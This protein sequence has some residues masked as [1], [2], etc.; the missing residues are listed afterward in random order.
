MASQTFQRL[1]QRSLEEHQQIHFY[2]DQLTRAMQTLGDVSD[3]EPIRRLA[4]QIESLR[5][6]IDEHFHLEEQSG[7]FQAVLDVL[8]AADPEVR[9]LTG[10]HQRIVQL[11]EMARI[12]A[13]G[14]DL[15]EVA[16]LREELDRFL[17]AMRQHEREEEAMIRR[18]LREDEPA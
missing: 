12:R 11:L 10:Q 17:Q 15:G 9:R 13:R 1:S 3:V 16:A 2:L 6:R 4:A 7:L 14:G 8:P 5:E 18:A